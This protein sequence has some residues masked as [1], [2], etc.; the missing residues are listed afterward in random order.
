MRM[1]KR[2]ILCLC[3]INK[4]PPILQ[5]SKSHQR[6]IMSDKHFGG[7]LCFCDLVAKM[8]ILKT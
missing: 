8:D 4:M 3:L 5:S 7:I 2:H 1:N 6:L